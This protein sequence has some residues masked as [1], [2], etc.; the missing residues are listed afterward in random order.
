M[1][2]AV[3]AAAAQNAEANPRGAYLQSCKDLNSAI[4]TLEDALVAFTGKDEGVRG[5]ARTQ[6]NRAV[7]C[8]PAARH[9]SAY[10]V[11]SYRR[12]SRKRAHG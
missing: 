8:S 4:G 6:R 7:A 2:D 11:S 12:C 10:R 1:A 3:N 9:A 5:Q